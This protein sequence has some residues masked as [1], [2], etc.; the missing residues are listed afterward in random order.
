MRIRRISIVAR[1]LFL[2]L[3]WKNENVKLNSRLRRKGNAIMNSIS[4]FTVRR[5][6]FPKEITIRIYRN[7]RAGQNTHAGGA[8]DGFFR[9]AYRL[10]VGDFFMYYWPNK[11]CN[12]SFLNISIFI[13]LIIFSLFKLCSDPSSK[14]RYTD[15]CRPYDACINDRKIWCNS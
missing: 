4:W 12:L 7:V 11:K 13:F 3:N 6:T 10:L 1:I 5:K 15:T 8:H 9:F 14:D 2:S